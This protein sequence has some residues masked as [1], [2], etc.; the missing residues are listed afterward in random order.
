M[1]EPLVG[2]LITPVLPGCIE[3]V[4]GSQYVRF[5]EGYRIGYGAVHVTLGSEVD[6]ALRLILTEYPVER[7]G[8]GDIGFLEE[9]IRSVLDIAEIFQISCI[10]QQ[11]QIND[12]VL[13][14]F[15]DKQPYYMRADEP[16][17]ARDNDSLHFTT[18]LK[19]S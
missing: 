14:I 13:R 17:S 15:P 9:I 2:E 6:H 19:Y 4:Y 1:V 8:V 16:C 3:Q 18:F 7:I 12:A 11:I 10:G 5:N